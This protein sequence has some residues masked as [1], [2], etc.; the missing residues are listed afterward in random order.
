ME[1]GGVVSPD[2]VTPSVS[3]LL[4]T[5]SEYGLPSEVEST[6]SDTQEVEEPLKWTSNS[7]ESIPKDYSLEE[8]TGISLPDISGGPNF[9][10]KQLQQEIEDWN[11]RSK[12]LEAPQPFEAPSL[13]SEDSPFYR[14][15]KKNVF[16][17]HATTTVYPSKEKIEAYNQEAEALEAERLSLHKKAKEADGAYAAYKIKESEVNAK[18]T[19]YLQ[20]IY[21]TATA[22]SWRLIQEKSKIAGEWDLS[23]YKPQ[24]AKA[25]FKLPNGTETN[26]GSIIP[27]M[28][29]H[30]TPNGLVPILITLDKARQEKTLYES[31]AFPGMSGRGE[32]FKDVLEYEEKLIRVFGSIDELKKDRKWG[33]LKRV[34]ESA[35]KIAREGFERSAVEVFYKEQ[36]EKLSIDTSNMSKDEEREYFEKLE[37]AFFITTA[38]EARTTVMSP[39]ESNFRYGKNPSGPRAIRV[40]LTGDGLTG[41]DSGASALWAEITALNAHTTTI[42]VLS[43]FTE[44][45]ADVVGYGLEALSGASALMHL[46]K[47]VSAKFR[48]R[49]A[50]AHERAD[51]ILASSI[52]LRDRNNLKILNKELEKTQMAFTRAELSGFEDFTLEEVDNM[53]DMEITR[54]WFGPDWRTIRALEVAPGIQSIFPTAVSLTAGATAAALSSYTGPGAVAIGSGVTMAT[55]HALVTAE[56]YNNMYVINSET[57]EAVLSDEFKGMDRWERLGYV[58]K[59]GATE[60]AG[61]GF[62]YLLL[63]G[64]LKLLKASR[65]SPYATRATTEYTSKAAFFADKPF[66]RVRNFLA[67]TALASGT[68]FFGEGAAEGSTGW[69]QDIIQQTDVEGVS[70][71]NIDWD[72][73]WER[74]MHDAR[75][76]RWM[77]LGMGIGG[78]T[79]QNTQAMYERSFNSSLYAEKANYHATMQFLNSSQLT[80]RLKASN[81]K[82]LLEQVSQLS[83]NFTQPT[84]KDKQILERLNGLNLEIEADNKELKEFYTSVINLRPDVAANMLIQ[85]NLVKHFDY[86]IE[87]ETDADAIKKAKKDRAKAKRAFDGLLLTG[88]AAI[89]GSALVY[90][91]N[92]NGRDTET[93]HNRTPRGNPVSENDEKTDW[94]GTKEHTDGGG[95]TVDSETTSGDIDAYSEATGAEKGI[96]QKVLD[97]AASMVENSGGKLKVIFHTEGSWKKTSANISLSKTD[98][99]G[100]VLRSDGSQELHIAPNSADMVGFNTVLFHEFGHASMTQLSFNEAWVDGTYNS[101]REKA[102]EKNKDGSFKNK[103]FAEWVDQIEKDYADFMGTHGLKL[104]M[105]NNFMEEVSNGDLKASDVGGYKAVFEAM[106]AEETFKNAHPF[107]SGQLEFTEDDGFMRMAA[108][109]TAVRRSMERKGKLSLKSEVDLKTLKDYMSSEVSISSEQAAE[110]KRLKDAGAMTEFI[111]KVQALQNGTNA[112]PSRGKNINGREVFATSNEDNVSVSAVMDDYQHFTEWYNGVSN[113]GKRKF[114]TIEFI[115]KDGKLYKLAPPP[116]Q[117]DEE[118]NPVEVPAYHLSEFDRNLEGMAV[119][120]EDLAEKE[121]M[122]SLPRVLSEAN[123]DGIMLEVLPQRVLDHVALMHPYTLP[124]QALPS[125]TTA[126]DPNPDMDFSQGPITIYYTQNIIGESRGTYKAVSI[127]KDRSGKEIKDRASYF[128][129]TSKKHLANWYAGKTGNSE[130]KVAISNMYYMKGGTETTINPPNIVLG[131]DGRPVQKKFPT[132]IGSLK[133]K[134]NLK[135]ARDTDSLIKKK[136]ELARQMKDL[137]YDADKKL[138][139]HTNSNDFLPVEKEI[140]IPTYYASDSQIEDDIENYT[141]GIANIQALID[142]SIE[143]ADLEKIAGGSLDHINP[144]KNPEIFN[145][146]GLEKSEMGLSDLIKAV[147]SADMTVE[148]VAETVTKINSITNPVEGEVTYEGTGTVSDVTKA[149]P[150]RSRG[151]EIS[152]SNEKNTEGVNGFTQFNPKTGVGA[153]ID[154]AT[155]RDGVIIALMDAYNITEEEARGYRVV[156]KSVPIATLASG[157]FSLKNGSVVRVTGGPMGAAVDY[158]DMERSIREEFQGESEKKINERIKK[159]A[160]DILLLGFSTSQ[161]AISSDVVKSS[162]LDHAKEVDQENVAV[163]YYWQALSK[164]NVFRDTGVFNQLMSQ[165]V[166]NGINAEAI[167]DEEL[168]VII[169]SILKKSRAIEGRYATPEALDA[170]AAWIQADPKQKNEEL[171]RIEAMPE[172]PQKEKAQEIVRLARGYEKTKSTTSL[173][174]YLSHEFKLVGRGI[175]ENTNGKYTIKDGQAKA[176][177]EALTDRASS[178]NLTFANRQL[179]IEAFIDQFNKLN[180]EA[181]ESKSELEA[182]LNDPLFAN[183]KEGDLVAATVATDPNEMQAEWYGQTPSEQG[184]IRNQ[185]NDRSYPF[186]VSGGRYTIVPQNFKPSSDLSNDGRKIMPYSGG[187]LPTAKE[188]SALPARRL[189]GRIYLK[190]NKGWEE[191]TATAFGARLQAWTRIW[192]D[193]YSDVMLLQQDVEVFRGEKVP[194]SQDFEMHMNLMYGEIRTDLERL[195]AEIVKIKAAMNDSGYT[196]EM[197]S[198]YLYAKHAPERNKLIQDRRP[199]MEDG[200]GMTTQEAEDIINELETPEMIAISKLVYDIVSNTRKT[201]REGG[202]E[203]ASTI[204]TWEGMYEYYIPLSGLAEDEKGDDNKVKQAYPTGGAGMAIYG[205]TTKA[206]KGRASKTGIN[207]IANVIMQNAMV[208]QRARKDL[209]MMSMYSLVKNN[210]NEKVWNVYSGKNPKMQVDETGKMV[211]MNAFEMKALK[212]MVPIRINGEQHF[213]YFKSVEHAMALNGMTTEKLSSVAKTLGPLMSF[214][215]NSF[216]QY[217]PSFFLTNYFRD[218]HGAM[219]NALAEVEREG[220]IM[221]GYGINS[222][223]F[224]KDIILGSTVTLRALLNESAFGREMSAE[225]VEY[226]EEWKAAGGRTGFSYSESINNVMETMRTSMETNVK[227][228]WGQKELF[229]T[230]ISKESFVSKEVQHIFSSPKTFFEYV[231][232]QNEAFENSIRLS[233]YIE[234]RKVGVTKQRAAQ[235]SKNI[236]INFNLSGEQGATMNSIFLFFNASVQGLSRFTRTFQ[237]G[238]AGR[239]LWKEIKEELPDNLDELPSWR[240]RISSAQKLAAGSVL[241]SAMTSMINMAMSDRDDD[242]EL[243]YNKYPDYKKERGLQIMYDG[244]NSFSAPLG[245]GYNMLNIAGVMLAEVAMGQRSVFD[246]AMFMAIAGHGSFSPIAFGH[247][248]TLGGSIVKGA[249]PTVL[250]APVDAFGFNET[251]FG[252]KVYK[253]QYPWGAPAPESQLSFRAPELVKQAATALHEMSNPITGQP[254][255]TDHI[256]GPFEINPD[257]WYYIMQSY[258]GGAGDFVEESAGMGRAVFEVA[259]RKYN[260]LAASANS[261]E[262]IDNLL[263]TPKEDIPIIKFSDVPAL[264]SMYGGPS[265]FYDFDLFEENRKDIEQKAKELD[266]NVGQDISHINFEGVQALKE[267]LKKTDKALKQVWA[268]R[269]AAKDI[270]DY[271][272]R[273]HKA[274]LLQEAERKVVM[275][276]NALY[277]QLRGQHVDPKPQGIIPL[278]DIRKAIGTDE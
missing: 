213:I 166:L 232:A 67:G 19:P 216:T 64:P 184:K 108:K 160:S 271:I 9:N 178:D 83:G 7:W 172:G 58:Q 132:T 2:L 25:P 260:K 28:Y 17:K 236:T 241:F 133:V 55:M 230:G 77:G 266:K 8:I 164:A 26:Y 119:N 145:M 122:E 4:D 24:K 239:D 129:I 125:R 188:V 186:G 248:E 121:M 205:K 267:E 235:L 259:R 255:G 278:N 192:Q 93:T 96:L 218:L 71:D 154:S 247:S 194:Q 222:K 78:V 39:E 88:Q 36:L 73:A 200:S 231:K 38:S 113:N 274:Y 95:L 117:L 110:E 242:D 118:G 91:V 46:P 206:A 270:E 11:V 251:Y 87:T 75:I 244:R 190:G 144:S 142:S 23:D 114:D 225:M 54:G 82:L 234:A 203:K 57:G 254:G 228:K 51:D 245:Y 52:E 276:F 262:F 134:K 90:T 171:E 246:A 65:V 6:A 198:D 233:A 116:Q 189:A 79:L 273:S 62:Q 159:A 135:I 127:E 261:D 191:S 136:D 181:F 158:T 155:I 94:G 269:R 238:K 264:K 63:M 81:K 263:S 210:P 80:S 153:V 138:H 197:V 107:A 56:T 193:K 151:V 53:V 13:L 27:G 148:E 147:M 201:M 20:E 211:P 240:N 68:G 226:V 249:M 74:A 3:G 120:N 179:I 141:I 89:D 130:A 86:I 103:K 18:L 115:G 163:V 170:Q 187:S 16:A 21:R 76:G 152:Y 185:L 102:Y 161:K 182:M 143:K 176:F 272:D 215:R 146:S 47:S 92:A 256:S 150:H 227:L 221:Q 48:E 111:S 183:S 44:G 250:K 165:Y 156:Y 101:L 10:S 180:S 137:W 99:G 204:E 31:E 100:Y 29:E 157:N 34:W 97:K 50:S 212:N 84:A 59:M 169:N 265:R 220:G 243:V 126:K 70:W 217:N 258:W 223:K 257:P 1:N 195:E 112:L 275:R 277:Y 5:L 66:V 85:D 22:K 168:S 37:R 32:R 167:T 40:D 30:V 14:G 128:P 33:G 61:E 229:D 237:H 173:G 196:A 98:G 69:L 149:L 105:I 224:T 207:L 45:F 49:G 60:A 104:E 106:I 109:F 140:G 162:A 209:A 124:T 43:A 177:V 131:I 199:D 42:K 123:M 174:Q 252:G 268:A 35:D 72:R 41:P 208:K 15:E 202:L 175:I 139:Q 219:Y 12:N 253:E 214:M